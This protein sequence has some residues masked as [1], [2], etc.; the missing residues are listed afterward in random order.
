MYFI[1]LVRCGHQLFCN[2]SNSFCDQLIV[3]LGLVML[4]EGSV[5]F[6]GIGVKRVDASPDGKRWIPPRPEYN[7]MSSNVLMTQKENEYNLS[8]LGTKT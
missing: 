3:V 7:C 2:S 5:F 4:R 6:Y 1:R 8:F